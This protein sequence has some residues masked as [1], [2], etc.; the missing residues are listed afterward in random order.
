MRDKKRRAAGSLDY[1]WIGCVLTVCMLLLLSVGT[2]QNA[3]AIDLS[4]ACSLTV[5]P[6][7]EGLEDAD[8]VIDLY[9]VADAVMT[10]GYDSYAF[11]AAEPYTALRNSL[12]NLSEMTD[13]DYQ[14]L[15]Q[16]AAKIALNKE[17]P[18][19]KTVDGIAV[20]ASVSELSCG[21]YLMIARGSDLE[22]YI[23]ETEDTD[24]RHLLVTKANSAKAVY[25]FSPVLIALPSKEADED[26]VVNTS[27]PGNW[28]Y[29]LTVDLKATKSNR[30]G[31]LEIMKTLLTY[32]TKT[33]A[34]FVFQVDA[35][36]DDSRLNCIYSD[37]VTMTFT[38][39]GQQ[40][41]VIADKIP[42]G[43]YVEVTEVYSGAVYTLVTDKTQTAVISAD[44]MASVSFTNDYDRTN[45]GGGAITNHFEN[46]AD[47]AGWNWTQ[48]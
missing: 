31:S 13:S 35:Y 14:N 33:P 8:V 36:E 28:F 20:N 21:L 7:L 9:K 47:G 12:E 15:A 39:A 17:N 25:T 45:G 5:N 10:E 42:V 18:A 44:D 30:F 43:A 34:T 23:A 16:Q 24:G 40:S 48:K 4:E 29:K 38:D 46:K 1:L 32:E 41:L 26:G 27:N 11:Q 37:V 19:E 2:V 6:T 22:D 3:R